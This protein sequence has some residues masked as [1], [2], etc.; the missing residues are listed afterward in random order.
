VSP[1]EL[2]PGSQERAVSRASRLAVLV[3]GAAFAASCATSPKATP[4]SDRFPLDPRDGL[5]GPFPPGVEAGWKALS[6]GDPRRART[7]F[8]SAAAADPTPAARIGRIEALVLGG[9][10]SEAREA[11]RDPLPQGDTAAFVTAC[12]EAQARSGE[13][14]EAYELYQRAAA[15]PPVRPALRERESELRLQARDQMR[16]KAQE[17]AGARDWAAGRRAAAR[18]IALDP[19]S[20]AARETAG[21]VERDAGEPA[22]ALRFYEEAL[23]RDGADK[24]VARKAAD[25]AVSLK[26]WSAAVPVLDRLATEDPKYE[27]QAAA[28][29]LAFRIANWPEP[30]RKAARAD[31]LSRGDAARLTWWMVPEVREASVS[32]GIIASDIVG[33]PDAREMTRA[34]SLGLLD[35]DT[36]TH[37]ARPDAPLSLAAAARLY[38][39]LAQILRGRPLDCFQSAPGPLETLTQTDALRL[40]RLCRLLDDEDPAPLSGVGFTRALDRARAIASPRGAGAAPG[41]AGERRPS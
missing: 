6:A 14:L 26:D 9:A 13:A 19:A 12:G 39:R 31:R 37:R 32:T 38:L 34:V 25:I 15:M 4:P 27:P 36:E 7:E 3:V 2:A 35:V 30:E 40:A 5:S 23:E 20:A 28:A 1:R 33:R 24:A 10:L 18:A 29:R 22:A 21:D 11:C 8:E 41:P 16:R 17:A